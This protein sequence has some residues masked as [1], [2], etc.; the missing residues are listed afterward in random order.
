ML[1]ISEDSFDKASLSNTEETSFTYEIK[2]DLNKIKDYID[3][4]K[5]VK[6]AIYKILMTE[7]N[8]YEIY[9]ENFGVTFSDLFGKNI[10][11]AESE[12][13]VRIKNALLKDSRITDVYDFSFSYPE[14]KGVISVKFYVSSIFGDDEFNLEVK[15]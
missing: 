2:Q 6:Q 3:G 15:I 9:D 7:K 14:G 8:K 5:A 4:I 10:Y 13:P 12:I 11:Y 1:P